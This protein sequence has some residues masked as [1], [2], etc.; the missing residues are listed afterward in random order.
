[1]HAK[2]L[3]LDPFP[4]ESPKTAEETQIFALWF[5]NSG[6]ITV[7]DVVTKTVL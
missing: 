1:M 7:I 3:S 2:P 5:P 4:Q 6:K